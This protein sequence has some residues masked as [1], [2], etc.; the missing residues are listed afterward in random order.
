MEV[1]SFIYYM[2]HY[3][4]TLESAKP[5][6]HVLGTSNANLIFQYKPIQRLAGET[7]FAD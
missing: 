7:V 2:I 5:I 1:F 3:H 6:G 4:E